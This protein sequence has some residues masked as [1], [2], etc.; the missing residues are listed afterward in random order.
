MKIRLDF[1]SNS[2]SSSYIIAIQNHLVDDSIKIMSRNS[3]ERRGEWHNPNLLKKNQRTLDFCFNTY[4]LLFL[5]NLSLHYPTQ[6]RNPFENDSVDG[7][8]V[9]NDAMEYRFQRYHFYDYDGNEEKKDPKTIKHRIKRIIELAKMHKE[10]GNDYA[11]STFQITEDTIDNTE[12]LIEAGYDIQLEPHE[13]LD[14]LRDILAN[15]YK[16]YQLEV[17][18]EGGGSGSFNIY[19]ENSSKSIFDNVLGLRIIANVIN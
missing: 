12:E 10:Y 2:S 13:S 17:S 6:P 18:Y 11:V 5:G 3:I 19:Q 14:H 7:I 15:G 8:V 16:I 4:Q 1:V 9:S